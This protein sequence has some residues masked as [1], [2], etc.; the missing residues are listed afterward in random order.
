M[1]KEHPA[2]HDSK[3]DSDPARQTGEDKGR[4]KQVQLT[5][6]TMP[7]KNMPLG[8]VRDKHPH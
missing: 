8:S 7:A 4:I 3:D 5:D 6:A 2:H 1:A